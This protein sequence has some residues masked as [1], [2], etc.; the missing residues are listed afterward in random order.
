MNFTD[1]IKKA[2][3]KIVGKPVKSRRQ[4]EGVYGELHYWTRRSTVNRKKK[5]LFKLLLRG[6]RRRITDAWFRDALHR[7][8]VDM[9][10]EERKEARANGKVLQFRQYDELRAV[11]ID[12]CEEGLRIGDICTVQ[13]MGPSDKF[14]TV[15]IRR[16]GRLKQLE[17]NRFILHKRYVPGY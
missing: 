17:V 14:I 12:D 11:N 3:N 1:G 15:K 16:N 7:T 10:R 5:K 9:A 6:T 4:R 8:G 13:G 2:F